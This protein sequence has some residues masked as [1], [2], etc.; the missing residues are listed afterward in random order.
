MFTVWADLC[1]HNVSNTSPHKDTNTHWR[2][3]R[4]PCGDYVNFV[5]HEWFLC[6][7][8]AK[9]SMTSRSELCW[10][11]TDGTCVCCIRMC[12]QNTHYDATC[13]QTHTPVHPFPFLTSF[14]CTHVYLY[15]YMHNYSLVFKFVLLCLQES[16]FPTLRANVCG[17]APIHFLWDT[18]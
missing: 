7:S 8:A 9:L 17:A 16:T 15:I 11:A 2:S 5:I 13:H 4:L 12:E 6:F 1:P 3:C 10:E 14:T 18:I